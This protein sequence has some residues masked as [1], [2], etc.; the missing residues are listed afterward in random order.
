[1]DVPG[2]VSVLAKE[3]WHE[4]YVGII[5]EEQIDYMVEK[6][7]SEKAISED[8]KNG[9]VYEI[10]TVGG[11]DAG[12]FGFVKTD[13]YVYLSK[14]YVKK[15]FRGSGLGWGT[16]QKV[17]GF[18][19]KNGCRTIRLRVNRNNRDSIKTYERWGFAKT[20][21]DRADIGNGF[22]MDDYVMDFEVDI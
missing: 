20:C 3:I 14:A 8:L 19:K 13:D 17:I 9:Y 4:W 22:F 6:F 16:L 5:S 1:M 11:K 21:E 15:E 7:Q 18:A 12:Y 2:R 10:I